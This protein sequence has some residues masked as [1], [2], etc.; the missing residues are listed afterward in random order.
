[1]FLTYL[2]DALAEPIVQAVRA[3]H[4]TGPSDAEIPRI[5]TDVRRQ[6]FAVTTD[7]TIPGAA[8]VAAPV[9]AT[10]ASLPLVVVIVLPRSHGAPADV[11]EM[12]TELLATTKAISALG[13]LP[14]A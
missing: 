12:S 7:A 14:L 8:A 5:K 4:P 10:E 13:Y 2:P 9:F 3:A 6:G 11:A 1:M